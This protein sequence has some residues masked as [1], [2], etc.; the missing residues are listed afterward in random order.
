[1]VTQVKMEQRFGARDPP[2]RFAPGPAQVVCKRPGGTAVCA[3][4]SWLLA[5]FRV[6]QRAAALPRFVNKG[7]VP[8]L[9]GKPLQGPK[10][11]LKPGHT[12]GR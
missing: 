7:A 12:Q 4:Y 8:A 3:P 6:S 11:I 5:L 2:L 1:M 10:V 9:G